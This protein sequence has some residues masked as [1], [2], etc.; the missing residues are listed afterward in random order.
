MQVVVGRLL[1]VGGAKLLSCRTTWGYHALHFAA[2]NKNGDAGL[3]AM[4]A[5]IQ[6][7]MASIHPHR[8]PSSICVEN[9]PLKAAYA[10]T[11]IDKLRRLY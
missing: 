11:V 6:A 3:Q 2:A 4:A 9:A 7:S 5:S 1:E 8:R 10:L